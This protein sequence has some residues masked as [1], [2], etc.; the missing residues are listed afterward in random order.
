MRVAFVNAKTLPSNS[1]FYSGGSPGRCCRCKRFNGLRFSVS[2]LHSLFLLSLLLLSLMLL[3]ACSSQPLSAQYD[4]LDIKPPSQKELRELL[5]GHVLL[6][7]QT[8]ALTDPDEDIFALNTEMQNFLSVYVSSNR[9]K[10]ARLRALLSAIV[11][12]NL[13][14][15]TYNP[16]KTYSAKDTFYYREGNCLSFTIMVITLAREI[17]LKAKFNEVDVPPTWDMRDENTYV[18]YKHVNAIIE[19][20]SGQ[21]QAVDINMEDYE[22]SYPQ[23]IISDRLATA[24]FYNNRSIEQLYENNIE[25]A[26]RYIRKAIELEPKVGYLWGSLGTIYRR[27]GFLHEAELAYLQALRNSPDEVVSISNL[28]RLY[29]QQQ[30]KARAELFSQLAAKARSRNPYYQYKQA[31]REL[32]AGNLESA[33]ENIQAAIRGY[34]KEHRF[35][36]YAAIIYQKMGDRENVRESLQAAARV[37]GRMAGDS[38]AKRYQNKLERFG[39]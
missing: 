16:F 37:A 28:E 6:Q 3:G 32:E 36:H 5:N 4:A 39:S 38:V 9:N 31:Q 34:G 2:D 27:A 10:K 20:E 25:D 14:G 12:K 11:R 23:R 19:V 15:M 7:G 35:Y 17:G 30:Q 29:S 24:Q 8:P 13:L 21:R 33:L 18:F 22:L 26:F 1:I